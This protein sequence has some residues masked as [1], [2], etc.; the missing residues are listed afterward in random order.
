METGERGI[1]EIE[2]SRLF[3]GFLFISFFD[4]GAEIGEQGRRVRETENG[5][6]NGGIEECNRDHR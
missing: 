4:E 3:F 1:K 5:E 6:Q 2:V